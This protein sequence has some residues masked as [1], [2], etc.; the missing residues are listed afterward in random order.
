MSIN[1]INDLTKVGSINQ[2]SQIANIA[3]K[4]SEAAE[5]EVRED[6]FV[7][8]PDLKQDETG[9]YSRESIIELAKLAGYNIG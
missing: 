8:S 7:K 1:N 6:K 4:E 9:I 5:K 3:A 2:T